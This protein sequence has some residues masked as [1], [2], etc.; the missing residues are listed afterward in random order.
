MQILALDS[1]MNGCGVGLHDFTN[2]IH[3][4]ENIEIS[5]GQAEALL[6]MIQSVLS[7]A[8]KSFEDVSMIAVTHGPGA[9]TGLRIAMATAKSLGLAL[10][11]PVLGVCTF[12]AILH[13]YYNMCTQKQNKGVAVVLE[14]KRRDFYFRGFNENGQPVTEKCALDAAGAKAMINNGDIIIGDAVTRFASEISIEGH[15]K[16]VINT[17]FTKVIAHLALDNK[18]DERCEP[19][20]IR[21]PDAI[22]SKNI[23]SI[24]SE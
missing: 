5:R 16:E 23:R 14:T 8:E 1:A 9:F 3:I 10:E 4:S 15:E 17:P 7:K 2:D 22:I 21:P 11:I 13:S 20:Y 12:E 19:V 18:D 6:P 24:K